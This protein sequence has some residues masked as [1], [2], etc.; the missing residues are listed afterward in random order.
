[1]YPFCNKACLRGGTLI[2]VGTFFCGIMRIICHFDF[3]Y[4]S[5]T[6]LKQ[7]KY[8]AKY[9]YLGADL[10]IFANNP[11]FIKPTLVNS[12]IQIVTMWHAILKM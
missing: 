9:Q 7:W 3:K 11:S 5:I 10:L 4:G 8:P 6:F 1:M 12:S 2:V